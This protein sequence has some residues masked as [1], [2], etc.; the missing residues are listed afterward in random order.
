LLLFFCLCRWQF[1]EMNSRRLEVYSILLKSYEAFLKLPYEHLSFKFCTKTI[2]I[3]FVSLLTFPIHTLIFH[4]IIFKVR[5]AEFFADVF[6]DTLFCR[7]GNSS[8]DFSTIEMI[9]VSVSGLFHHSISNRGSWRCIIILCS[10]LL[11]SF[12]KFKRTN[13]ALRKC[14]NRL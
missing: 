14:R 13:A 4:C 2:F 9:K 3:V 8:W 1:F 12:P 10:Q 11:Q 7:Y 5:F 6:D